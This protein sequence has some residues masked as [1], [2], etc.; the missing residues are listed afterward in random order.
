MKRQTIT[1]LVVTAFAAMAGAKAAVADILIATAGPMT[2]QYASF[3][4]QMRRGAEM[5]V[6]DINAA[7]GVLGQQLQLGGAP[8]EADLGH[9]ASEAY[10]QSAWKIFAAGVLVDPSQA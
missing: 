1:A 7:G 5:A 3:G 9:D 6:Q 8:F 2:G 10:L 4:E